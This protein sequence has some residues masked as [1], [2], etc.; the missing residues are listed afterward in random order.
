MNDATGTP[1]NFPDFT[2]LTCAG[3]KARFTPNPREIDAECAAI[4]SGWS[5]AERIQRS[6]GGCN[7]ELQTTL[8][9]RWQSVNPPRN[10]KPRSERQF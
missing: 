1:A 8:I 7:R 4:Q 6:S 10:E 2:P 5:Q 9:P 3:D